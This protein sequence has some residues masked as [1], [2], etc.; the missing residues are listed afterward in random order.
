[1]HPLYY[2]RI[3]GEYM[4]QFI[5]E[6]ENEFKLQELKLI[7]YQGGYPM[8]QFKKENVFRKNR[9]SERSILRLLRK[10]ETSAGMEVGVGFCFRNTA[11]IIDNNETIVIIGHEA[12]IKRI[13]EQ[14]I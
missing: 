3:S 12:V 5:F 10:A 13:L 7:G 9:M 1:M 14:I 4:D 11:S 6:I 8:I 2:I